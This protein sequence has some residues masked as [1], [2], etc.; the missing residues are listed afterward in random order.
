MLQESGAV[1]PFEFRPGEAFML[2]ATLQLALRHPGLADTSTG[3]FIESLARNIEGRVCKTD[4]LREMARRGWD[5]QYDR[6]V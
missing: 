3:D 5:A 4:A 6:R 2:L 1:L